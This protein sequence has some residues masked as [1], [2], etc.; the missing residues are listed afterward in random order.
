MHLLGI[1]FLFKF[2]M[3]M[4]LGRGEGFQFFS[5]LKPNNW[6]IYAY[7]VKKRKSKTFVTAVV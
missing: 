3:E 4:Q 5:Y 1:T 7:K 6:N 2:S